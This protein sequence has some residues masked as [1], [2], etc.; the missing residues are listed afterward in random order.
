MRR[1]CR[2]RAKNRKLPERTNALAVSGDRI[3]IRTVA[4]LKN[5]YENKVLSVFSTDADY[6]VAGKTRGELCLEFLR[7]WTVF[8]VGRDDGLTADPSLAMKSVVLG[9]PFQIRLTGHMDLQYVE[10]VAETFVRCLLA[11]VE[12]AFRHAQ[13]LE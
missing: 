7:P 11:P 6:F 9:R 2:S 8:G 5:A 13:R 12:G 4:G 3:H 1:T 10:D